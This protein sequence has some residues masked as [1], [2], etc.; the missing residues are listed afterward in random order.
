[1][2]DSIDCPFQWF[3]LRGF[4]CGSI[5]SRFLCLMCPHCPTSIICLC[6]KEGIQFFV[7]ED[8]QEMEMG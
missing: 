4:F 8:P 7:D 5:V 3:H 1:M 2:F 6:S